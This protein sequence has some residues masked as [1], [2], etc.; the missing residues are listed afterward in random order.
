VISSS[1][2]RLLKIDGTE[3]KMLEKW[4]LFIEKHLEVFLYGYVFVVYEINVVSQ[5]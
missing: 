4:V 1:L 2:R 5:E 3:L